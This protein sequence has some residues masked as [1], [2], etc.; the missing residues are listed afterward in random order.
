MLWR[1]T[2]SQR[3]DSSIRNPKEGSDSLDRLR[4][5]SEPIARR[6]GRLCRTQEQSR[7]KCEVRR[8]VERA[9]QA[10]A[11]SGAHSNP[12]LWDSEGVQGLAS[13]SSSSGRY[14]RP[15]PGSPPSEPISLPMSWFDPVFEAVLSCNLRVQRNNVAPGAVQWKHST[16]LG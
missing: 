5:W 13:D 12:P 4:L 6:S 7:T 1:G 10:V 14:F 11:L 16:I 15:S 9:N 8:L 3:S 2:R